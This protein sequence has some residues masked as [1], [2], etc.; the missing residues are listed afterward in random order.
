MTDLQGGH[1][2]TFENAPPSIYMKNTCLDVYC[3]SFS[4]LK[5]LNTYMYKKSLEFYIKLNYNFS[6]NICHHQVDSLID[7]VSHA[8]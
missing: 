8:N 3:S 7:Y 4:M 5:C 1:L 6:R 2:Q